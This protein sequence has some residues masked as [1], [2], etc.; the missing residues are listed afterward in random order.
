MASGAC[1]PQW[2][3][4][5]QSDA[6]QAKGELVYPL[7]DAFVIA[8]FLLAHNQPQPQRSVAGVRR[9]AQNGHGGIARGFE[10]LGQAA[11]WPAALVI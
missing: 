9:T 2:V 10:Q 5:Q 6:V 1:L 3:S 8:P 7:L 4:G 11:N